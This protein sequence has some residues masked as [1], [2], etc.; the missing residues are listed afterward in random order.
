VFC[1]FAHIAWCALLMSLLTFRFT[2]HFDFTV[3]QPVLRGLDRSAL[4]P[5]THPSLKCRVI[6]DSAWP[7]APLPEEVS[8]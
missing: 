6:A 5:V 7:T 2:T 1:Y 3:L 8:L 4:T